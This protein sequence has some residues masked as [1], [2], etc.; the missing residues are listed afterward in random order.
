MVAIQLFLLSS[1][2]LFAMTTSSEP[3]GD[4]SG[5]TTPAVIS[6]SHNPLSSESNGD[7]SGVIQNRADF[8]KDNYWEDKVYDGKPPP[9]PIKP[10][11]RKNKP[12]PTPPPPPPSPPM[13]TPSSA[14]VSL[15]EAEK[16][17]KVLADVTARVE[18]AKSEEAKNAALVAEMPAG[19]EDPNAGPEPGSPAADAMATLGKAMATSGPTM[20]EMLQDIED[21]NKAQN[22]G[23]SL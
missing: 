12:P 13:P 1:I 14:P 7:H 8:T 15:E 20:G 23:E 18:G 21:G 2:V 3:N 10:L 16:L 5:V 22:I 6:E 11:L 17:A 4:H 19:S 9:S